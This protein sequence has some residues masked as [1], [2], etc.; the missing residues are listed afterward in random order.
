MS[1]N[2]LEN[3][4]IHEETWLLLPGFH[5]DYQTIVIDRGKQLFVKK[6]PLELISYACLQDGSTYEGRKMAVSY[7]TRIKRKVPIPIDPQKKIFA[8]PT[9]APEHLQCSWIFP[10]HVNSIQRNT[11]SKK[12]TTIILKDKVSFTLPV[13][14]HTLEKQLH[15]ASYCILC[16]SN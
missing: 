4:H 11:K 7:K 1:D 2:V 15:R 8:F 9:H 6:T 13:S 3:Y 5:I 12:E 10:R 16:F 14:F